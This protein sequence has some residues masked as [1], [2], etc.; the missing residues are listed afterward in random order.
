MSKPYSIKVFIILAALFCL[1]FFM[2]AEGNAEEKALPGKGKGP[3]TITAAS[4]S[5]D[6]KA[7]RAVFEGNVAAKSEEMTMHSDRMVVLYSEEGGVEKIEA[8]GSVRLVKGDRVVTSGKAEYTR[9]DD[10]VVFT[11][12]PKIAEGRTLITGS[13]IIYYMGEDRTSVTDSKVFIERK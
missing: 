1:G 2:R 8:A 3:I 7:R 11:E 10:K 9:A 12:N 13:K 4:L 5:A 6:S